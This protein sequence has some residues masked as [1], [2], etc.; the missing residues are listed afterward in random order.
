[1][2]NKLYT[3]ALFLITSITFC[4]VF[5]PVSRKIFLD[6]SW[7]L[8]TEENHKYYRIIKDYNTIK[9]IYI[10]N[11]FYKSGVLQMTGTTTDRNS[12]KNIGQFVYYYE[13]GIKR[14]VNS[15][16]QGSIEGKE[17][18]WYE[19]GNKRQEG[20]YAQQV[21]KNTIYKIIQYWD[22]NNNQ[23]VI[24]GNGTYKLEEDHNKL[25][26]KIKNGLRDSIWT[27]INK[28]YKYFE[29][30]KKG[31]LLHGTTIDSTNNSFNY[32]S[33][34]TTPMPTKG[35]SH[36]TNYLNS[37]IKVTE[38]A[39]LHKISGTI[40]IQFFIEKNGVIS[41]IKILKSLGFG[42]NEEAIK[43][44]ASYPNWIPAKTRGVPYGTTIQIPITIPKSI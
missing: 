43:V 35:M 2:K 14:L 33:I 25:F 34:Y 20:E 8:T 41:N 9:D 10:V 12:L 7:Q 32:T 22:Q 27:G 40:I 24:N 36:F 28:N 18:S 38:N 1:M 4:Q 31:E 5:K 19:N 11:D 42:I 29:T 17:Y 15:Y 23:T 21:K 44:L 26:G 13:S 3:I 30:Y 16:N 37:K 6:S 39:K